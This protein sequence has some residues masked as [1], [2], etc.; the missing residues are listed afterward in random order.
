MIISCDRQGGDGESCYLNT[1]FIACIEN[2]RALARIARLLQSQLAYAVSRHG[3]K[4]RLQIVSHATHLSVLPKR[5][6]VTKIDRIS[7]DQPAQAVRQPGMSLSL[8]WVV[9]LLQ[10]RLYLRVLSGRFI[11]RSEI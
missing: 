8:V 7:R 10:A 6:S 4:S 9:L 11:A 5:L 3:A 1:E 2:F